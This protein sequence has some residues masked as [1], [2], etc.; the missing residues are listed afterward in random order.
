M[1]YESEEARAIRRP[2]QPTPPP[3]LEVS[4]V[5]LHQRRAVWFP[6]APAVIDYLPDPEP[7]LPVVDPCGS[8][9][10]GAYLPRCC[11]GERA[12]PPS[13]PSQSSPPA[14]GGCAVAAL[15]ARGDMLSL[16]PGFTRRGG[17]EKRRR[18]GA[19]TCG[20][21]EASRAAQLSSSHLIVTAT[22]PS[23]MSAHTHDRVQE[24]LGMW[25]LA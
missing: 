12:L 19:E 17:G 1:L 21:L 15:S 4:P 18:T 16:F 22:S 11:P 8:D 23:F 14:H 6:H 24:I 7:A 5:P 9:G 20:Q 25:L 10:Q 3:S 13:L 2:N